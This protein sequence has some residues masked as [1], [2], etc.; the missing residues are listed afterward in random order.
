MSERIKQ[1]MPMLSDTVVDYWLTDKCN[2]KCGFCCGTRVAEPRVAAST[3][4]IKKSLDL[5]M[6]LGLKK[7]NFGGGEPLL[8]SDIGEI[9][10][11]AKRELGLTVY[12]STN[13]LLLPEKYDEIKN[14]IDILGLPLDG[15]TNEMNATM[16][17]GNQVF[18]NTVRTLKKFKTNKP[19]HWVKVGTV[20][21]C[22]NRDDLLALA[23]V[24]YM[25]EDTYP[26]DVWRIYQFESS[27]LADQVIKEYLIASED[28]DGAINALRQ[29]FPSIPVSVRSNDGYKKSYLF[30]TPELKMI[31]DDSQDVCD[32]KNAN[33]NELSNAIGK[34]F[35]TVQQ[36]GENRQ[37]IDG[38]T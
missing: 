24:L 7:V 16:G 37:W 10:S 27:D 11:Y 1:E 12:L 14:N 15:S 6:D 22:K 3:D 35:D 36:A 5:L 13:G 26:P 33:K 20:L 32:L 2:L 19:N 30:V 9:T 38:L 31:T 18:D 29:Q 23:Q 4:E 34:V 28:Y 17:R 21:S 25:N 8:R